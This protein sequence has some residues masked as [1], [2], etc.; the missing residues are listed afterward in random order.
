M[1]KYKIKESSLTKGIDDFL[2]SKYGH[3][4]DP[5]PKQKSSELIQNLRRQKKKINDGQ[6]EKK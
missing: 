1:Q 2:V 5:P 6:A 3:T 4:G